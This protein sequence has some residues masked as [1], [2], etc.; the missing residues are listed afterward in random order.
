MIFCA[1]NEDGIPTW[2]LILEG[3]KT[4]TR[5]LKPMPI[6]KE[7]AIQ[8]GRGK[9][10]IARGKVIDCHLHLDWELLAFSHIKDLN[11]II[12]SNQEKMRIYQLEAER[13]GFTS[14]HGLFNWLRKNLININDTYR[15]EFELVKEDKP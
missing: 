1:K 5:R 12:D 13:E 15:I 14:F 6:G 10:A 3:K 2:K 11:G 4:V 9:K 7:F 8:P